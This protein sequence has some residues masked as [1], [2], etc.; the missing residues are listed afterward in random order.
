MKRVFLLV[1]AVAAAGIVAAAGSATHTGRSGVLAVTKDCEGY[2]GL[3]GQTC[4]ITSSNIRALELGSTIV[5]ASAIGDPTPG[6]L[7]SDLVIHGPRHSTAFGHVVL[8]A[9][10]LTGVVTLSGGTGEFRHFHAG[11]LA[12]ACPDF[13]K[14]CT[15]D[16]PYSFS[17]NA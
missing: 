11:P 6:V 10:T 1:S 14:I 12:V 2:M 8:D 4:T 5:Y 17:P 9:T 16:G 15:W 7:D 3:A 13:P